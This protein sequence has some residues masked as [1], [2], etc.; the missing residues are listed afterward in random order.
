MGWLIDPGDRVVMVVDAGQRLEVIDD[1]AVVIPVP[2]FAT[3][4]KLTLA[5]VLSWLQKR[6]LTS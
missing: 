1:L 6:K 3:E 4:I 2:R 5:N